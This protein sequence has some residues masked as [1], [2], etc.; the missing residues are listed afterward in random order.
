MRQEYTYNVAKSNYDGQWEILHE[1]EDRS[2][3][4]PTDYAFAV[5][6]SRILDYPDE[7]SGGERI[8]IYGADDDA[9]P[10]H[11]V[12]LRVRVFRGTSDAH[13]P[14]PS[15]TAYLQYDD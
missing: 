2:T 12:H 3:W 6:Q 1:A 13:E 8:A 4:T 9:P 5:L 7:A 10:D 11:L 15:A 14:I